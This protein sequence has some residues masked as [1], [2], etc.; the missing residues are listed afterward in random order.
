MDDLPLLNLSLPAHRALVMH[1][2]ENREG[3]HRVTVTRV[4][5]QRSLS[6]NAY[7]WGVVYPCICPALSECEGEQIDALTAHE[8]FKERFLRRAIVNKATG[9]V[10]GGCTRS[11]TELDVAEFSDFLQKIIRWAQEKLG[12]NVPAAGV[13]ENSNT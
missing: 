8:F 3:I 10:M 9:E 11:S 7:L 13:Y 1:H 5:A 2:I 4:K 6:Q 12:L